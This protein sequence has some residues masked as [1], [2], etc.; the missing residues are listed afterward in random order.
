MEM[1]RPLFE[2]N[3]EVRKTSEMVKYFAN[4]G[5]HSWKGMRFQ[6]ILITSALPDLNP[7][8]LWV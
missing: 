8:E 6:L 7:L 1:G 2:S 4:E 5:K 3:I